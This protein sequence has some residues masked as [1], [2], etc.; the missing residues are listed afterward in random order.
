MTKNNKIPTSPYNLI[1]QSLQ[2]IRMQTALLEA[3]DWDETLLEE[4]SSHLQLAF[5]YIE[6]QKVPYEEGKTILKEILELNDWDETLYNIV[7][8]LMEQQKEELLVLMS[9][10]EE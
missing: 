4:F 6:E 9:L 8:E 2:S 3:C 10:E 5:I 1:S 7:E